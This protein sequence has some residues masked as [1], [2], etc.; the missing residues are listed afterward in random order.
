VPIVVQG[1]REL[2]QAFANTDRDTRL[3]WR[4]EQRR[5][6]EP[7]R[8]DAEQ[9]AL[10]SIR[11]MPASPKWAR[12]RTGVTR[13]AVYVAPRQRGVRGRGRHLYYGRPNLADLLETR[14]LGPA[15]EAHEQQVETEI[16]RLMDKV[17]AGFNRG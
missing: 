17:A 4:A 15:G 13:T 10:S 11:R 3:G 14:A 8:Q 7:I 5:I 6:A 9:R 1:L 12:M 16:E 2:N